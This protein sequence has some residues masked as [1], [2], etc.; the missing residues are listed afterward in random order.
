M[1]FFK[2]QKPH[3]LPVSPPIWLVPQSPVLVL[4]TVN[5]RRLAPSLVMVLVLLGPALV[6]VLAP[7]LVQVFFRAMVLAMVL[8]LAPVLVSVP[9]KFVC[10]SMVGQ[11]YSHSQGLGQGQAQSQDQ[12]KYND[13]VQSHIQH[14]G[15]GNGEN[16]CVNGNIFFQKNMN[17]FHFVISIGSVGF[18]CIIVY[19]IFITGHTTTCPPTH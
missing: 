15:Q 4:V 2:S 18:V 19:V 12:C 11:G 7:A 13:Q 5:G 6:P 16:I 9:A 10:L 1:Y 3:S 17:I 8:A 14:H